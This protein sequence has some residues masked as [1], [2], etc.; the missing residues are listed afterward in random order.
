MCLQVI[1][2]VKVIIKVK[3][4][5]R[6]NQGHLRGWFA[7][8]SNAFLLISVLM[9][10]NLLQICGIEVYNHNTYDLLVSDYALAVE[11]RS[12]AAAEHKVHLVSR[13]I[14]TTRSTIGIYFR[15]MLNRNRKYDSAFT[16][17][18]TLTFIPRDETIIF[19]RY[20]PPPPL[21]VPWDVNTAPPEYVSSWEDVHLVVDLPENR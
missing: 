11:Y 20:V 5:S 12:R 7:F 9:F 13:I 4:R 6:S 15:V 19:Q 3:S 10:V 1:N 21:T 18:V 14:S 17:L 8:E 2:K 16:F